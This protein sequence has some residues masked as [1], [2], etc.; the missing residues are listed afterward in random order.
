MFPY[1]ICLIILLILLKFHLYKRQR[2]HMID[3]IEKI[4]G[5]KSYP[6]IGSCYV[7]FSAP[8]SGK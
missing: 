4:P 7:F 1:I 2:K 8:R 6:V 3:M 5:P